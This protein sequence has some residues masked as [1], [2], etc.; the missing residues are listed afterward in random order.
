MAA[1]RRKFLIAAARAAA[2][3]ALAGCVP[4]AKM[5]TLSDLPN[6][7]T[8]EPGDFVWPKLPG[9]II[10]YESRP[11]GLTDERIVWETQKREFIDSVRTNPAASLE[12][13]EAAIQL[14]D[15]TFN[16]FKRRYL[17]DAAADTVEPFSPDIL[18]VGHVGIVSFSGAG[19]PSITE[20]APGWGIHMI[21]YRE[22]LA[23]RPGELVWHG[24]LAGVP[25]DQRALIAA[26][27][28]KYK[29]RPYRFFNFNLTDDSGFYCS[30]LAWLS[31]YRAL[32]RAVDNDPNPRRRF[33]FSPKQLM[34]SP[35]VCLLYSPEPY[36]RQAR[37]C[38]E[39]PSVP[40]SR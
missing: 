32:G 7:A 12:D 24:R 2:A 35:H 21:S 27:A 13:R 6:P 26:E 9:M 3:T 14:E 17:L 8:F 25:R 22:W 28:I 1:S 11:D 38:T 5:P 36:A 23:R 33:W 4:F 19:E 30:K 15:I 37:E 40:S 34:K 29:G 39:I 10:P 31:A 18:P 20:A 16:A